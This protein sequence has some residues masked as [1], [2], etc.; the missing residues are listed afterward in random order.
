MFVISCTHSLSENKISKDGA[1]AI[2]NGLKHYTSLWQLGGVAIDGYV[3]V[4]VNLD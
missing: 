1:V 4:V 3:I 2:G